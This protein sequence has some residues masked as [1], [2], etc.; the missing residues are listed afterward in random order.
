[1]E[2]AKGLAPEN[3]TVLEGELAA[4]ISSFDGKRNHNERVFRWMRYV[5]IAIGAITAL[6]L[7]LK[8]KEPT[9]LGLQVGDVIQ[10]LALALT[11]T[12]T[13]LAAIEA[14]R[15]PRALW[16]RYTETY[17]SL[18]GLQTELKY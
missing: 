15:N 1:M 14:F 10:N 3:V 12:G 13:A 4:Q 7:G 5:A 17:T 2:S 16:I 6:L 9:L 18:R 11:T 8:I